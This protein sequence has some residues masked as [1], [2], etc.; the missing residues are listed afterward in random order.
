MS[1]WSCAF[2]I[3]AAALLAALVAAPA[4]TDAQAPTAPPPPGAELAAAFKAL[5]WAFPLAAPGQTR[6]DDGKVQTL[7]GAARGFTVPEINDP[8][9]PPDWYPNEH[10][11]APPVVA[12][13][14][15]PV[16]R[17]CGQCHM[18]HGLGHPESSSLAGLPASYIR[19][20]MEDFKTMARKNSPLMSGMA[21]AMTDQ[22]LEDSANYYAS[23]PMQKWTRIV[24]SDTV[25]KTYVGPG[26]MRFI[27]T[28]QTGT[29]PIAG[30]IIELPEDA[31][32][33]ELRD[34][35]SSFMAYVPPGSI[36]RGQQLVETGGNGRTIRCTL[37]HGADLK[38]MGPVPGLAGRSP[39][40]VVRQL[41]GF[42]H[43]LREGLWSSLMKE[44]VAKL[45]VDDLVA[46]AA[47]TASREP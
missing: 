20:Q 43:G 21:K 36:K 2:R 27:D 1:R 8:F 12:T 22:E 10:P 29:E 25:P 26:N 18:L 17:A 32:H 14:R 24:E 33:A 45:T 9:A 34:P 41:Y 31:E 13:G 40:Y 11:P 39:I 15:R 42:Q 35:H 5:P 16:V 6:H 4:L 19:Q 3:L 7:P 23:I 37:C 47:Y 38:G 44:A 28:K 30:R 46:I